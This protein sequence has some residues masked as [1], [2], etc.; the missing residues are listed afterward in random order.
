MPRAGSSVRRTVRP[1][2]C[3]RGPALLARVRRS[4][5]PDGRSGGR[6]VSFLVPCCAW[7]GEV[8]VIEPPYQFRH[9]VIQADK[10]HLT[11][12]WPTLDYFTDNH[13][14]SLL[15]LRSALRRRPSALCLSRHASQRAWP[16]MGALPQSLQRPSSAFLAWTRFC[17]SRS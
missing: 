13:S 11:V 7:P 16:L 5:E 6:L 8:R 12:F 4:T 1:S 15:A 9:W 2:V 17:C 10:G 3:R 14:F